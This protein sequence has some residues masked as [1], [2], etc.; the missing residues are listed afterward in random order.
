[1]RVL[2]GLLLAAAIA[3]AAC[4]GGAATSPD[5]TVAPKTCD[6]V[7]CS[8]HGTCAVTGGFA[9][10]TCEAGYAPDGPT[11]CVSTVTPTL[12]GCPLLPANHIFNTP[13]DT[14]PVDPQSAAYLATIGSHHVHLDLG[15]TTD[16]TSPDFYGIPYNVVHGDSVGWATVAFHSADPG[17]AWN[18]RTESDCVDASSGAAH[19]VISPCTAAAAANPRLPV[20]PS[21]LVEGGIDPTPSQPYGDHHVLIV[22][23]DHCRLWETYHTYP[24]S[25]GWDIFG[26]AT[27]DLRSAALRP[28]GWTSAD[29][30][31]FP[32]LPLLLRGDEAGAGELHHALRFTIQSNK[33]RTGYVWPA[34]HQ[35][36]NGTA[37]TNLP[38]MGQLFRLKASYPIPA[39]ATPRAKAILTALKTYGMYLADGG[40][41]LYITGD[42][43]AGWDDPTFSQVQ[44]VTTSDFEA[45][46]LRPIT[47]RAGFDPSSGAV[48]AP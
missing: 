28:D 17:L 12:G 46:D 10:C 5:A 22:D 7:T 43:N 39:G 23:V 36:D 15:P 11:A 21:P 4:G 40:S 13:I 47:G 14:L 2:D 41:D 48:P 29:A 33:I 26:A 38:S 6:G 25:G 9:A 45:V 30:A 31:G 32:I 35:T 44:A 1:M 20:P 3:A 16:P 19:T 18:P 34:R 37:S 27:F 42:P 8:G 24:A